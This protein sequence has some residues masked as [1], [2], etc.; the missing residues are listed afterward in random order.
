MIIQT[1]NLLMLIMYC[2]WRWF[3]NPRVGMV[4]LFMLLLLADLLMMN[5]FSFI[6]LPLNIYVVF[7]SSLLVSM[8]KLQRCTLL[9]FCYWFLCAKY[10]DSLFL[11]SIMTPKC[12]LQCCTFLIRFAGFASSMISMF[13][14]VLSSTF[15]SALY[16]LLFVFSSTFTASWGCFSRELISSSLIPLDMM[17]VLLFDSL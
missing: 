1:F 13:S 8:C 14:Y 11:S 6:L 15:S 10:S 17:V 7:I 5:I 3:C 16:C 4:I 2:L 9:L 12:K